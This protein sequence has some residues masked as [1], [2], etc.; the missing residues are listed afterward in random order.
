MNRVH[1]LRDLALVV[2]AAKKLVS[3]AL[4]ASRCTSGVPG[5]GVR[6]DAAAQLVRVAVLKHA[7]LQEEVLHR[8]SNP[9]CVVWPLAMNLWKRYR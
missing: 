4:Q 8:R 7:V 3:A 6:V 1:A 5:L 2:A 9:L